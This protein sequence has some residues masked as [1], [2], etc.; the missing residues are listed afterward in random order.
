MIT[1]EDIDVTTLEPL[2]KVAGMLNRL[3][4]SVELSD[5]EEIGNDFIPSKEQQ[6][7]RAIPGFPDPETIKRIVDLVTSIGEQV[8]P[9]VVTGNHILSTTS[10][11]IIDR[12]APKEHIRRHIQNGLEFFSKRLERI[13]SAS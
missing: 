10:Q 2:Q 4:R 12:C 6:G 5:V 1:S 7:G 13:S 8:L 11:Q 3:K 9:L